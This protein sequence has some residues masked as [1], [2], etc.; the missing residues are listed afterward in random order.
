MDKKNQ[1][2][3]IEITHHFPGERI[4]RW[5]VFST[6]PLFGNKTA[7]ILWMGQRVNTTNFG[8]WKHVETLE[9]MGCLPPTYQLVIRISLAHPQY[10]HHILRCVPVWTSA[11]RSF[12]NVRSRTAT[13]LGVVGARGALGAVRDRGSPPIENHGSAALSEDRLSMAIPHSNGIII[14]F[15]RK[16]LQTDFK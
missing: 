1:A 4:G 2:L 15:P 11:V 10:H 3:M 8:F 16:N 13:L 7:L 14:I 6:S 9:I 12:E 5:P